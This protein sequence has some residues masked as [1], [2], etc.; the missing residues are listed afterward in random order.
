[1]SLS[2]PVQHPELSRARALVGDRRDAGVAQPW[3]GELKPQLL[4]D[5]EVTFGHDHPE[6]R[7]LQDRGDDARTPRWPERH[8][9]L[10]LAR[11]ADRSLRCL[12]AVPSMCDPGPTVSGHRLPRV[13]LLARTHLSHTVGAP[14]AI[15]IGSQRSYEQPAFAHAAAQE[16]LAVASGPAPAAPMLEGCPSLPAR[17]CRSAE[18]TYVTDLEGLYEPWAAAASTRPTAA[19]APTCSHSP[20]ITGLHSSGPPAMCRRMR[21]LASER[22]PRP[23]ARRKRGR[24]RAV[25]DPE[26]PMQSQFERPASRY[27]RPTLEARR[28]EPSG[29]PTRSPARTRQ[30]RSARA[31]SIAGALDAK[32]D[33]DGSALDGQ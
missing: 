4:T 12:H 22:R 28:R 2:V 17:C 24:R 8:R 19:V 30:T 32:L 21:P 9:Q 20:P 16:A 11:F 31:A 23:A 14:D 18:P 29:C 25:Q 15:L 13:S 7:Q 26:I 33:R 1:V 10:G 27:R 5:L 3:T 6:S